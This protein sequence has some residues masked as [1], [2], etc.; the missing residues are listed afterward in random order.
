MLGL[1]AFSLLCCL[2]VVYG[3]NSSPTATVKN[4]T[5]IGRY[6]PQWNQD[7][8]LGIPYAQPPVGD[9]RFRWPKSLNASFSVPQQA[10]Q[11]GY[12]CYQYNTAF[13]L[14]EDCLTLNVVR[15]AGYTNQTLPVL[16]WIYGGGLYTGSTA[17]QQYNLSGIVRTAEAS[18]SPLI[19]VSMNYRL[20]VWGFLQTP[21]IL[22]EGSSNAGLL[23]QRMALQWVQDN[24]AAFGGDPKRVT[25]WGESAGAQSIGLHLHSFGGR[26]DNLF[27]SAILESGG[28][29]GT[30]L[31]PLAF[32]TSPTENLTRTVGC[33]TANDQLACLRS[34][35]SEQLFHSN[36]SVTWNPLVDGNFLTAYPSTL[37]ANGTFIH[38]PL[39]IGANTDEGVSF[40]VHGLNNETAIFN[41]LLSWRNY[42]ISPPSART[43][44]DLY[45][46]QYPFPPY[47]D[48]SNETFSSLGLQWRRD[49]AIG[50]DLVII[51]QRRKTAEEFTK[52][53]LPVYS[54]RFDTQPWNATATTGVQH[55]V[56]VVFSFQNISGALGPLPE[57]Q[58]YKDLSL[59][60]GEAYARFVSTGN[61]NG[62]DFAGLRGVLGGSANL[63]ALPAWERYDLNEPVN[64]VLNANGSFIEADTWRKE[65]I[66]FINTISREL[67]S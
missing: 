11:Y 3:A 61:P 40:S 52:A 33:Y 59:Q 54:Y 46:N 19:A 24:I 31:K 30:A 8:F 20:G 66:A 2:N 51:A 14:S 60:I 13:N 58:S 62:G 17:D 5:L 50:G 25:V 36:Y 41:S 9:L 63:T 29:I 4:G 10:I 43:L 18:G 42:A 12:S 56:N 6:L 15:P 32:Y 39:L 22:A 53:G 27:Q 21:Q 48:V 38:V 47:H 7:L 37:M 44:L 65:G 45:P 16:I 23:D 64:L 55:F 57:F 28:P 26:D 35:S 49:A 1:F 67:D 34:L